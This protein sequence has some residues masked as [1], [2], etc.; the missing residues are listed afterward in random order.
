MAVLA[1]FPLIGA[2]VSKRRSV[3]DGISSIGFNVTQRLPFSIAIRRQLTWQGPHAATGE[4]DKVWMTLTIMRRQLRSLGLQLADFGRAGAVAR[5]NFAAGT[6]NLRDFVR[7]DN[8][9]LTTSA[10]HPV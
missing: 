2:G 9:V 10:I 3:R 8:T 6:L 5:A 7:R 1:Q 4:V